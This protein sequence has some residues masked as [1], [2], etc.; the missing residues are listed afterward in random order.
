MKTH[1]LC[2]IA[3]LNFKLGAIDENAQA[4]IRAHQQAAA[5]QAD[6]MLVPEM[7]LSGYQLDDLILVDGF[8]D[9]IDAAIS[10]LA[11]LTTNNAPAMIICAPRRAGGKLYNSVYVLDGGVVVATRDKVR[12]PIG[13]VFDDPRNFAHGVMPEP[14][15]IRG[16]SIGLPI[17]EDLWHADVVRHICQHGADIILCPNGSPFE[18]DKTDQRIQTAVGRAVENKVPV[19]Y[20]NLVGGQ[21]DQIFDGASFAVNSDGSLGCHMPS[22]VE[23]LTM[24]TLTGDDNGWTVAGTVTKPEEGLA[25]IWRCVVLGIRD[26]VQKNGFERVILGLSGGI[27]SALV[28]ALAVDALGAD[29]V[30]AVM[31]PS[32]YTSQSSLDDAREQAKRLGIRLDDISI[33]AGMDAMDAALADSF[34]RG[35]AGLARE[36]LQ[37]RLRGLTLMSISN[38]TG[39]LVL[40]TGNKSEYATGYATLYG[41]MCGAYAPLIDVWKTTVFALATWRNANHP[42]GVL[43]QDG[44]VI[45]PDIIEKPPSAELRPD[46]KDTDS[47]PEYAVLDDIM[48]QLVEAMISPSELIKNGYDAAVVT[49]CA[50]L[51]RLAEY[52]RKQAAPGPKV[53]KRAFYRDRRFPITSA[54]DGIGD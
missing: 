31:M 27:D 1:L 38:T 15:V 39:A 44:E 48:Q 6:I 8:M 46:Q 50:R 43:G 7:Y 49:R 19:V 13:G 41:D 28:A 25:A 22:F 18:I 9:Q 45:Y 24:I 32:P 52:K 30:E 23:A 51:L 54:Y 20:V 17:C 16:V 12:L 3:Q 37:S 47:L 40:T 33:A 4:I 11:K 10:N 35:D 5:Q 36:N 21:D 26:Y 29:Q 2:A 42:Q 14:V 34:A 53:T